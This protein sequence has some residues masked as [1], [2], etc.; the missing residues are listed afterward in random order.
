MVWLESKHNDDKKDKI[1]L[2]TTPKSL[3]FTLTSGGRYPDINPVSFFGGFTIY[4]AS[5]FSLTN[6]I[7]CKTLIIRRLPNV[8]FI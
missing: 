3:D 2:V 5:E 7:Y 6:V 1:N 8:L 4:D